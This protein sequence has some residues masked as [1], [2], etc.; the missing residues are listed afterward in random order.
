[1]TTYETIRDQFIE[2]CW[3][4][5]NRALADDNISEAEK[6]ISIALNEGNQPMADEMTTKLKAHT[7]KGE[8][9]E[10]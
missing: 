2:T 4:E 10:I 5:F 6:V 9:Q 3:Q 7:P 1:M 8:P